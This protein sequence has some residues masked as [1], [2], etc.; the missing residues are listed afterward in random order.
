MQSM[1]LRGI[2]DARLYY[3]ANDAAVYL[4]GLSPEQ[5]ATYF[6]HELLD[7]LFLSSYSLFFVT[8][9]PKR[10]WVGVIPGI[11]DLLETGGILVALKVG[12]RPEIVSWLGWATLLKWT[13]GSYV[14]AVLLLQ[15]RHRG[16]KKRG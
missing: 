9:L 15:I 3:S 2:L 6:R 7:L 13:T 16:L 10:K 12:P 8:L 11:F 5:A 4:S 14:V 1:G